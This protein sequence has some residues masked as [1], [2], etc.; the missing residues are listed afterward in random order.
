MQFSITLARKFVPCEH[1]PTVAVP[2]S[3]YLAAGDMPMTPD[4]QRPAWWRLPAPSMLLLVLLLSFLPWIEIGCENKVDTK[5]LLSNI[6]V[7]SG[8]TPDNGKT[9]LVSQSGFQIATGGHTEHNAF[10]DSQKSSQKGVTTDAKSTQRQRGGDKDGLGAA[11]LLFL[12]FITVLAAIV[13]GFSMPPSRMRVLVVGTLTGAALIVLL[14]QS[15][16]IGFPA[17]NDVTKQMK[18]AKAAQGLAGLDVANLFVRYT[19]WY[20]LTWALLLG[21]FI[22]LALEAL[23]IRK[24]KLPTLPLADTDLGQRL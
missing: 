6:G 11:P 5:T 8:A 12:F 15:V 16:I 20:W 1:G 24:Q 4:P 9:V 14:I 22:P 13:G 10:R 17:V 19:V 7:Q 21:A 3:Q 23:L 2:L 18:E